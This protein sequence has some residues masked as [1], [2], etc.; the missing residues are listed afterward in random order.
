MLSKFVKNQI[1]QYVLSQRLKKFNEKNFPP[2]VD[3]ILHQVK[4]T[5]S[6]KGEILNRWGELYPRIYDKSSLFKWFRFFKY[7]C[8]YFDSRFVP[9]DIYNSAFELSLNPNTYSKFMEHKGMLCHFVDKQHKCTTIINRINGCYYDGDSLLNKEAVIK[10]I[11][12]IEG[13]MIVLKESVDTGGGHGVRVVNK[14]QLNMGTFDSFFYS[15]DMIVEEY[16]KEGNDLKKYNP[17]TVNTIRMLT[18]N[19]NGECSIAS[20]FLRIGMKGM[21]VDNISSGGI[22]VGIKSDGSLYDYAMDKLLNKHLL[23]PSGIV[24]KGEH[25][26]CYEVIKEY[27]LNHHLNFPLANLV[28]WDF[29]INE[30]N[31][32]VVIEVNLGWGDIY[33]HQVYNG[34]LFGTRTDEIINYVK[35]HPVK[36]IQR[37]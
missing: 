29:A 2:I 10:K 26:R 13:Q 30:D 28:A 25:L 20:A 8:G 31:C 18:I 22:W 21:A 27:A 32:V 34:P 23:S 6:E 5:S 37:I 7:Q 3:N 36:L 17:D 24:F 16:L 11:H 9:G 14:E 12:G 15:N 4:L 35:N 33:C 19:L 1:N